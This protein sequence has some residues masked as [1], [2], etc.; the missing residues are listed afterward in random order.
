MKNSIVIPRLGLLP[1]E[2][3]ANDVFLHLYEDVVAGEQGRANSTEILLV[4]APLIATLP[5]ASISTRVYLYER[6]L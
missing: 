5:R 3:Y 4:A 6:L 1:E 2:G